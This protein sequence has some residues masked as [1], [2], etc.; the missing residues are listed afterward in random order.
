MNYHTYSHRFAEHILQ[1]GRFKE[2]FDELHEVISEISEERL[3]S[4]T[5]KFFREKP[6]RKSI[7]EVI[8][9]LIKSGLE[10]REWTSETKIFKSPQYANEK[11]SAWRLD[12]SKDPI[13]VEVAFNHSGSIAHNLVKP[14]LA[15]ELNHV[16]KEIQTELGVII[17]ASEAL[18]KSGGFDGAIGSF[19]DYKKYL[20]PYQNILSVPILLIGLDAPTTFSVKVNPGKVA[21]GEFKAEI[22]KKTI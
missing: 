6:S 12:F 5:E 11:S 9:K 21:D 10:K 14:V 16:E 3:I 19:D 13:S 7:S 18:K 17:T 22:Q 8:N 2:A 15:S 20:I 1:E 4:E